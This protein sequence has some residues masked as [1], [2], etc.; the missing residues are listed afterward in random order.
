MMSV[1]E[2]H[3]RMIVSEMADPLVVVVSWRHLDQIIRNARYRRFCGCLFRRMARH[4]FVG[5]A[6]DA[7]LIE[8]RR[9]RRFRYYGSCD[10][11]LEM[12]QRLLP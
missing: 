2:V 11:C 1:N 10:V 7:R 12:G 4:Y 3:F 6:D 9:W 5:F 8:G